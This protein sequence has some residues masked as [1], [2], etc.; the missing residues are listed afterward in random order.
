LS[1]TASEWNVLSFGFHPEDS[2][3]VETAA[4]VLERVVRSV[5][6]STTD[7]RQKDA[8]RSRT[9]VHKC[10]SPP[11]KARRGNRNSARRSFREER[12]ARRA[13][14]VARR[15]HWR[16]LSR[17]RT[18]F[19]YHASECSA[20]SNAFGDTRSAR[21]NSFRR[22][23]RSSGRLGRRVV[24]VGHRVATALGRPTRSCA[25]QSSSVS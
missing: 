7:W 22:A 20:C 14:R 9:D 4:E 15:Q 5:V 3:P 8:E 17:G 10:V 24:C 13:N 21:R 19:L 12:C 18:L 2:R 25:S 23:A 16:C 6:R 1:A 11:E